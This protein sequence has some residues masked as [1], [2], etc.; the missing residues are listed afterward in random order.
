MKRQKRRRKKQKSL[1]VQLF[2]FILGIACSIPAVCLADDLD[3]VLDDLMSYRMSA[4]AAT[5][6]G[7]A[8]AK[9]VAAESK[10]TVE[11]KVSDKSQKRTKVATHSKQEKSTAT[12]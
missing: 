1:R 5:E 12:K 10:S 2:S 4:K 11:T 7:E 6:R 9:P 3:E 8:P